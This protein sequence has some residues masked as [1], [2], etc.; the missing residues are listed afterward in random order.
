MS[1]TPP[2]PYRSA[3]DLPSVAEML[4][5]IQSFKLL[6]RIFGPDQRSAIVELEEKVNALVE[7]IDGFYALLG[8]RNWIYHENLNT[9]V[10]AAFLGKPAD[11]A[12]EDLIAYYREPDT[13]DRV[14]RHLWRFPQMQA[15]RDLILRAREDYDAER[16]DSAT[17]LLLAVMDGFVNDVEGAQ[18][19]GLHARSDDEMAA[20]DSVVGHH[21]GLSHAHRTF[22]KTFRKTSEDEVF[23]LYRNGIV[24]GMLPNFSNVIVATKAWNRLAAVADWAKSREKQAEPKEPEPTL[25]E[26]LGKLEE[27]RRSLAAADAWSASMLTTDDEGFAD[28]VHYRAAAFL[29]AWK[30]KNYGHMAATLAKLTREESHSKNAGRIRDEYSLCELSDFKITRL[31]FRAPVICVVEADLVV[32]GDRR[33]AELRWIRETDKGDSAVEGVTDGDWRVMSWGLWA[34]FKSQ[35]GQSA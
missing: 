20:W 1:V 32:D 11:D 35:N 34:M 24:H 27:S 10:V 25:M 17:M 22:T 2:D 30:A 33:Q 15:R 18:R 8:S 31:D 21:Q 26:S 3:R 6:S 28:P 23:E 16:F 5:Q 14:V 9:E 29:E 7:N 13:L 4:D 12:E 19:R